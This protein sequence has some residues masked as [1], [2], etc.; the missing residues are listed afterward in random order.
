MHAFSLPSPKSA[1]KVATVVST[2]Q[3]LSN[4]RGINKLLRSPTSLVAA[5]WEEAKYRA[6]SPHEHWRGWLGQGRCRRDP[7]ASQPHHL[8]AAGWSQQLAAHSGG[9]FCP[10]VRARTSLKV[11]DLPIGQTPHLTTLALLL[12]RFYYF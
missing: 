6:H 10:V 12:V 2:S 11:L 1:F 3:K 9:D 4:D 7:A 5:H 8:G